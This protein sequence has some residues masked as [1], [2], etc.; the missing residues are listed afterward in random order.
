[1]WTHLCVGRCPEPANDQVPIQLLMPFLRALR[2]RMR[3]Y[4]PGLFMALLMTLLL[5]NL[6]FAG[7]EETKSLLE[8][9]A[10]RFGETVG[11]G[12]HKKLSPVDDTLLSKIA[13]GEQANFVDGRGGGPSDPS[14]AAGWSRDRIIGADRL[15]WL[16]T[17]R[18]A[19]AQVTHRG[20]QIKGA[21][22][23]CEPNK[24]KIDL[25]YAQIPFPIVLTECAITCPLDLE[26]AAIRALELTGSHVSGILADGLSVT[27]NL[28]FD[29]GFSSAHQVRLIDATVGGEFSLMAAHFLSGPKDDHIALVMDGIKVR[30]D[31]LSPALL[32][33]IRQG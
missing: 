31:L 18:Q 2:S 11:K 3:S 26:Q 5:A 13:A 14:Q 12:P 32:L 29:M 30:G 8:L 20:I 25:K 22:I 17:N 1:M 4:R 6:S 15:I 9:A 28:Q 23:D 21:R 10:N 19:V 24:S 27:N 16:C 33:V 7:A